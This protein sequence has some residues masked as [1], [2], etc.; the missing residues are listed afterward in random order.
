M[1]TEW[2]R[3]ELSFLASVVGI[4]T[5]AFLDLPSS[6]EM[7]LQLQ[8]SKSKK[9][10]RHVCEIQRRSDSI[11][12]LSSRQ[13][14]YF[15]FFPRGFAFFIDRIEYNSNSRPAELQIPIAITQT[16]RC[17]I[18]RIIFASAKLYIYYYNH[19]VKLARY[20]GEW[21]LLE[22]THMMCIVS[23]LFVL[24]QIFHTYIKITWFLFA[25]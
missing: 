1:R 11:F 23:S 15:C 4:K 5:W 6:T 24:W 10:F 9:W 8:V 22:Y 3:V 16:V 18:Y 21:W 7:E 20:S 25:A 14:S 17:W 12:H 13:L 19:E 2:K